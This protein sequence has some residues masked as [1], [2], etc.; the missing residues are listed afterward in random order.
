MLLWYKND[1]HSMLHS[2]HPTVKTIYTARYTVSSNSENDLHSMLH[3]LHP[4]AELNRPLQCS[5]L[6]ISPST[7]PPPT[8]GNRML[9]LD[10]KLLEYR[11]I[12]TGKHATITL[13]YGDADKRKKKNAP[14]SQASHHPTSRTA[15]GAHGANIN[16]YLTT[17]PRT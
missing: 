5:L 6:Q 3:S 7:S 11:I 8:L 14:G 1:L 9:E 13:V 10:G 12:H 17:G 16:G 2:L 15:G 4:T